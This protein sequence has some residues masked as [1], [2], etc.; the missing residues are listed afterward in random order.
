MPVSRFAERLL[1][2]QDIAPLFDSIRKSLAVFLSQGRVSY[3]IP[4]GN[5]RTGACGVFVSLIDKSGALRG[6][7]GFLGTTRQLNLAAIDCA[8][9]AA[10]EDPRYRHITLEELEALTIELT[11]IRNVSGPHQDLSVLGDDGCYGLYVE[12]PINAG[13]L[14][15]RE[16]RSLHLTKEQALARALGKAG[17]QGGSPKAKVYSFT[18]R[19]FIQQGS[20]GDVVEMVP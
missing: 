3:P 6:S 11:L 5:S 18:A 7:M 4:A 12:G 13:V 2:K 9:A 20:S 1:L 17:M 10:S 15:P 16:I 19:V 14:L 8:I